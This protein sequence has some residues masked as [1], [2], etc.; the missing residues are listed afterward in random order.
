M[1]WIDITTSL[2]GYDEEVLFCVEGDQTQ[3]SP[4]RRLRLGKRIG[5][6]KGGERFD[7]SGYVTHWA[8]QP[9]LPVR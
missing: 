9:E 5:T 1:N 2:P 4:P 8:P 3:T 6:D 7:V